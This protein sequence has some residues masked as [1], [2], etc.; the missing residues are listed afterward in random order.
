M[1]ELYFK[2]C[3]DFGHDLKTKVLSYEHL[4]FPS[5]SYKFRA[6]VVY[7]F[8]NFRRGYCGK[9]LILEFHLPSGP[10]CQSHHLTPAGQAMQQLAAVVP[11]ARIRLLCVKNGRCMRVKKYNKKQE[12]TSVWRCA[13]ACHLFVYAIKNL[14]KCSLKRCVICSVK[15]R[16]IYNKF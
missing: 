11:R 14:N 16:Y 13:F 5:N 3:S 7:C 4:D 2:I 9:E 8:G 15:D 10:K 1:W 6:P 12:I